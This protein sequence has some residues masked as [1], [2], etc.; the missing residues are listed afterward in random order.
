MR[1]ALSGPYGQYAVFNGGRYPPEE[2]CAIRAGFHT[3][4]AWR[5]KTTRSVV[6]SMRSRIRGDNLFDSGDPPL[7][8]GL[9]RT[10]SFKRRNGASEPARQ[11]LWFE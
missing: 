10:I 11:I 4:S 1:T 9:D 2:R 6:T 3:S 8:Y 7:P 5:S